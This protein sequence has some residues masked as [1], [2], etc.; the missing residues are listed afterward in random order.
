[1]NNT[2][3]IPFGA[4]YYRAP[5]PLETEWESDIKNMADLGFNT[6]KIW[7][8]W[9]WNNPE[10]D[11][12]NFS[13]LDELMRLSGQYRL[14]VIINIILDVAPAW[15]FKL[16]PESVMITNSGSPI[17]PQTTSYRQIGGAPGPCY[18]H[19]EAQHCKNDFVSAM[20]EHYKDSETLYCWDLWNEPELTCG[21][22]REPDDK[23]M[24][25]YCGHSQS[26]FKDWLRNKYNTIEKLNSVW[27]RNYLSFDDV[28]VPRN[29]QVFRDM[30]DWREYHA[31]SL[32][33]DLKNR[34]DS[35][36]KHDK[37]HPVM[38]HTV[39]SPYFNMINSCCDDYKMAK[40]CDL[41][42]NSIGSSPFPAKLS[43]CSAKGKTIINAEIHAVGGDTINRPNISTFNNFKRHIFIPFSV[44]IKGFLF[45]Q[46]RPETLGLESPAWGLTGL[47]GQPSDAL[48]YAV[49][50]NNIIQNNKTLFAACKPLKSK[51]AIVKDND[52]E[53]FVWCANGSLE[54][55]H[56]SIF[57]AFDMFHN[58]NL[59]T[60]IITE[61]QLYEEG[62][63]E[64]SLIYY[65]FPYYMKAEVA[66]KL[67]KWIFNGG[68]L[69]TESFFGG[70]KAEDG[71][72][73]T[74]IPGYGFDAV[75]GAREESAFT[76]SV[77]KAAYGE[78]W[79]IEDK[80][81][82]IIK[83]KTDCI[84]NSIDG[85]FFCESFTAE[86]GQVFG[87]Y[88][89]MNTGAVINNY[90]KGKAI[91]MGSLIGAGYNITHNPANVEFAAKIAAMCG[92][93]PY[94]TADSPDIRCDILLAGKEAVLIVVN[95]NTAG[96]EINLTFSNMP[97]EFTAAVC[98]ESGDKYKINNNS[99]RLT[100]ENQQVRILKLI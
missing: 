80:S 8:Q 30:I 75:F 44:G 86:S 38:V 48:N 1:M 39:P 94:V 34:A 35:V 99:M 15:F 82:S 57:G 14:K 29:R 6:I 91:L 46:Y 59:N 74:V 96:Y 100:A 40:H 77:F 63:D 84:E 58:A 50:I 24:V 83:I 87:A 10:K 55:F 43:V 90:G 65:P 32:V 45:W 64:Y 17:M 5:T 26:G 52:N 28:E 88:E 78:K 89:N 61:R 2:D 42:G 67:K 51:I 72:H 93:T 70:Y 81:S 66:E 11:V 41:F 25:C 53:V 21:I 4:Q 73:S 85:Y 33:W 7:A 71:L 49:R 95:N 19:P 92:I 62:I 31:D 97:V 79:G 20:S 13:D 22:A 27:Q 76:A 47:S 56:K 68:T 12:Y 18:H 9:R 16:Y 37:N 23:L 69:L 98:L 60:D 3:F 36:K 54:K